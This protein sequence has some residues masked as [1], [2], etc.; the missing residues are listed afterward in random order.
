MTNEP[1]DIGRSSYVRMR[2]S[3]GYLETLILLVMGF[4][5]TVFF[6]GMITFAFVRQL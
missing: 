3:I 5:V 1:N 2:M 4:V 6:R